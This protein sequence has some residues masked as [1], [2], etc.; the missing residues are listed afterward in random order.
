MRWWLCW[1]RSMQHAGNYHIC[2]CKQI[3]WTLRNS[4]FH[5]LYFK[6]SW[7]GGCVDGVQCSMQATII[8]ANVNKYLGLSSQ[9]IISQTLL[10]IIVRLW[11]C[12]WRSMQH[13]GNCA[14]Y[15]TSRSICKCKQMSWTHL[16]SLF[17]KLYFVRWWLCWWRS[18]Q[19]AGN[20][21][22]WP[23]FPFIV[24]AAWLPSSL[25]WDSI[26]TAN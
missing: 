18:M 19:H 2:K 11:L 23:M 15:M 16:N 25:G 4:F 7:G 3:S 8:S 9:L 12:W 21:H 6:L 5:K 22:D 10:Q 17:H 20:Y 14:T 26:G 24:E 1:W 13:A